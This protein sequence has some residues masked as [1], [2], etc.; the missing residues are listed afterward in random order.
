MAYE[1]PPL[2]YPVDAL[3]PHI[4]AKTMEI[5]HDK[6]HQAYVTG[7]NTAMMDA[8]PELQ[9]KSVDDLLRDLDKIPE[10]IRQ[11]VINMGGGHANH[12]MFWVIMS[13]KGGG[14]PKGELG[15]AIDS[16]F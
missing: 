8:P 1:L 16:S 15:K 3:E 14:E 2:P 13:P 11:A 9:G 7:L 12:S 6:H 5:H 10:K 4:D